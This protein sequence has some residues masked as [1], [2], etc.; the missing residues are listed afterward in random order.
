[1]FR[2]YLAGCLLLL[3][4][5]NAALAETI[6]LKLPEVDA[7]VGDQIRVPLSVQG[8]KQMVAWQL[9]LV[10]DPSLLRVVE[11]EPGELLDSANALL[12]FNSDNDGRIWIASASIQPISEDGEL[13]VVIYEVIGEAG[14]KCSLTLEK[15]EA[16]QANETEILIETAN[17]MVVVAAGANLPWLAGI[18][19][20]AIAALTVPLLVYR[21]SR[22]RGGS[23]YARSHVSRPTFRED[24]L[25]GHGCSDA[26]K[27]RITCPGCGKSLTAPARAAGKSARCSTCGEPM[28]VPRI[29]QLAM[30]ATR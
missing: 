18:I 27:I 29:A 24:P 2:Q 25:A 6:T 10:H 21:Q 22:N 8:A 30:V 12:E 7:R 23:M 28:V 3:F 11:T 26:F 15:A 20:A 14:E 9:V 13:A 5:S 17:G 4:L 1:M 19:L 16:W